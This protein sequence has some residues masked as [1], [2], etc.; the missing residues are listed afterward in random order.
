MPIRAAGSATPVRDGR[1][2]T[3]LKPRHLA[4]VVVLAIAVIL[5]IIVS[6]VAAL[7]S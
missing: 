4:G 7:N 2:G 5:L 6:M 1:S 3:P